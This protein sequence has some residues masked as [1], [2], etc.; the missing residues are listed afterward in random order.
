VLTH[1]FSREQVDLLEADMLR[2][3]PVDSE[4]GPPFLVS[5][6]VNADS[7]ATWF[8]DAL[9]GLGERLAT[10][11]CDRNDDLQ[12]ASLRRCSGRSGTMATHYVPT[13]TDFARAIMLE[14]GWDCCW[15]NSA[16]RR[17][18][19]ACSWNWPPASG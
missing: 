5:L 16:S 7:L 18:R 12:E 2:T 15:G 13:S 17:L 4:S 19:R 10:V 9:A 8:L 3:L 1:R 6:A 14:F 11:T